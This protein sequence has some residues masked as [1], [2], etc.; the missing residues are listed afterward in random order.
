VLGDRRAGD[1]ALDVVLEASLVDPVVRED[2]ETQYRLHDLVRAYVR[3]RAGRPVEAGVDVAGPGGAEL[4]ALA[5]FALARNGPA[6]SQLPTRFIPP[7]PRPVGDGVRGTGGRVGVG[8]GGG[9]GAGLAGGVLD[10]ARPGRQRPPGRVLRT[11]TP[12]LLACAVRLAASRPDLSWRLVADCALGHDARSDLQQW[13]DAARV[14][15]ASLTGADDDSRL[16]A[17][18]LMLCRAWLLQSQRSASRVAREVAEEARRSLVSI[19]AHRPAAAAALVVAQAATSL[20]LRSDAEAAVTQAEGWLAQASDGI[21]AAWAAITRGTL[22]NDYD[23]LTDAAWEFTRARDLL[24]DSPV[25]V[26]NALATLELSRARRRQGELGPASL[27]IDEALQL[28]AE[29]GD[30]HLY[31]YALDA[32]AEVS[33]ASGRP[34]EALE[35]ASRAHERALASRDAF[36]TARARRTR[37]RALFALGRLDEAEDEVRR[38]IEEFSAIDRPLSVAF[39]YQVLAGVLKA[40]GESAAAT[41]ALRLERVALRQAHSRAGDPEHRTTDPA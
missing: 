32:R 1:A 21:L 17:A 35:E 38:G 7:A 36:L 9:G 16:G 3:G 41:E 28:F 8:V 11:D 33:L 18:Y 5:M 22:H 14:V 37:G 12:L 30:V 34:D 25:T 39:S 4:V 31:S 10:A 27:L 24:A 13:L 15:A 20:G 19:A 23:E 6:L 2:H 40:K 29:I 26:A